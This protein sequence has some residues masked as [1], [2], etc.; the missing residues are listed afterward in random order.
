M[1]NEFLMLDAAAA[2][3]NAST[4]VTALKRGIAEELN[5]RQEFEYMQV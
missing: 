4:V 3:Y 5:W 2:Q 1:E